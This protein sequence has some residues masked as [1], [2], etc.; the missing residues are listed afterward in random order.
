M[1][2]SITTEADAAVQLVTADGV[3]IAPGPE[4]AQALFP[5]LRADP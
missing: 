5:G 4:R 1:T 3:F 2:G